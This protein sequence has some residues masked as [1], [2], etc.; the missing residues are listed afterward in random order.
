MTVSFDIDDTLTDS[1]AYFIPFIAEC[2]GAECEC[3]P[4][5]KAKRNAFGTPYYDRTVRYSPIFSIYVNKSVQIELTK[6]KRRQNTVLAF[7]CFQKCF[8]FSKRFEFS[9]SSIAKKSSPCLHHAE[10]IMLTDYKAAS[11]LISTSP[12]A[13]GRGT[14]ESEAIFFS[15]CGSQKRVR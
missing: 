15:G 3:S 14:K 13:P 7:C 10:K 2:F 8:T 12:F 5:R 11:S 4:E 6:G 1:F 9:S